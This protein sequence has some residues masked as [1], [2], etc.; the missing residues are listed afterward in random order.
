MSRKGALHS[1]M[2]LKGS[3]LSSHVLISVMSVLYNLGALRRT[4]RITRTASYIFFLL[5]LFLSTTDSASKSQKLRKAKE[6]F[7]GKAR[8]ESN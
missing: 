6:G 1:V 3:E 4:S 7:P 8:A 2:L 5:L